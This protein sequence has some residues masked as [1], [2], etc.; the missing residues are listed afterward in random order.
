MA[1]SAHTCISLREPA[2]SRLSRTV[3][4]GKAASVEGTA[5]AKRWRHETVSGFCTGWDLFPLV[6]PSSVALSCEAF[7]SPSGWSAAPP[8]P[9]SPC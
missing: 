3:L 1:T 6:H 9:R 5:E 7:S 4:W 8:V 2:V